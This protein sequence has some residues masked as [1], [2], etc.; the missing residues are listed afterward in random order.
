MQGAEEKWT[1]LITLEANPTILAG[2]LGYKEMP[3]KALV[4][5]NLEDNLF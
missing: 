1:K 3:L 5:S 4:E 2:S